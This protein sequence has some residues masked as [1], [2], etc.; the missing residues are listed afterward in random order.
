MGTLNVKTLQPLSCFIGFRNNLM[1][2]KLANH[3]IVNCTIYLWSG[4]LMI[5]DYSV[6]TGAKNYSEVSDKWV[7]LCLNNRVGGRS[8]TTFT[9]RGS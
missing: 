2:K 3:P 7:G 6:K 1:Q 9:R 4:L 5:G 8:Q